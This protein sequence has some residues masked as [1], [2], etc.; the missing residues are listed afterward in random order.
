MY[1]LLVITAYNETLSKSKERSS[2]SYCLT[3]FIVYLSK[4]F[5]TSKVLPEYYHNQGAPSLIT[6][7]EILRPNAIIIHIDFIATSHS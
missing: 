4:I 1:L 2:V 5:V 6:T 7:H 3:L